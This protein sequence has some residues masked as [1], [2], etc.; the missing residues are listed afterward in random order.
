MVVGFTWPD[1]PQ[2]TV[3]WGNARVS[4]PWRSLVSENY[5][6]CHDGFFCF[7]TVFE[8]VKKKKTKSIVR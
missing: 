4:V 8:V 1:K 3:Q 7:F 2:D 5:N 6:T